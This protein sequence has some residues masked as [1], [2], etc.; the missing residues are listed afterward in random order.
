[1]IK[2]LGFR[3]Y[4]LEFRFRRLGVGRW[5]VY[6]GLGG[7]RYGLP[8]WVEALVGLVGSAACANLGFRV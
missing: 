7:S 5:R 4:N 8:G 3:V 1:M 2:G 6:P